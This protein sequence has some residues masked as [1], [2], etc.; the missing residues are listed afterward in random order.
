MTRTPIS[1]IRFDNDFFKNN[2]ALALVC[3][4][5][6]TDW[7]WTLQPH[8]HERVLEFFKDNAE[9]SD[10]KLERVRE[11]LEKGGEYPIKPNG[12]DLRSFMSNLFGEPEIVQHGSQG[13]NVA[14][15]ASAFGFG[16]VLYDHSIS[17]ENVET[18]VQRSSSS[19]GLM[20]DI[21]YRTREHEPCCRKN[22]GPSVT[23]NL[24]TEYGDSV[25][26]AYLSDARERNFNFPDVREHLAKAGERISSALD[27]GK[28]VGC[29]VADIQVLGHS[30]DGREFSK[31]LN[32]MK[33][34]ISE[35]KGLSKKNK[36]LV[37]LVDCGG[38][39][40]YSDKEI[41]ELYGA[42]YGHAPILGGNEFEIQKLD[43]VVNRNAEYN[44]I[45]NAINL[46]NAG[47]E[48]VW[49]HTRDYQVFVANEKS[50][51]PDMAK[52]LAFSNLTAGLSLEQQGCVTLPYLQERINQGDFSFR[53]DEFSVYGSQGCQ[54]VKVPSL[55]IN[56]S[57]EIQAGDRAGLG[58]VYGLL[59]S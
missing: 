44:H 13:L 1:Q 16:P 11:V 43:N 7:T 57:S 10:E 14:I 54:I 26:N 46:V 5:P 25:S 59:K 36:G 34:V 58:F 22:T 6:C 18:F 38:L 20:K 53:G 35:V 4:G 8:N 3:G 12:L 21:Y 23:I 27:S 19:L 42:I 56:P 47:V 29:I 52:A 33:G 48:S 39:S 40:A 28:S 9:F 50:I 45:Q 30:L 55:D 51:H 41:R 49:L 15:Q 2:S 24:R 37:A 17:S 32:Y 31:Y